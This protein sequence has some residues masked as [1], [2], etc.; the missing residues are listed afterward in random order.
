L[1]ARYGHFFDPALLRSQF[2]ALEEPDEAIVVDVAA[3]PA[4]IVAAI[5]AGL[6]SRQIETV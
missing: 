6:A 1:A 5:H 3:T 4:E 2:E